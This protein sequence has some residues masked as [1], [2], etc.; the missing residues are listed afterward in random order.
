[1]MQISPADMLKDRVITA[2]LLIPLV[3]YVV[4][5]SPS[6]L[7]ALIL[8]LI[9]LIAANEW[10]HIAKFKQLRTGLFTVILG[11]GMLAGL[12][13]THQ[14]SDIIL[15]LSVLWWLCAL[16]GIMTYPRYFPPGRK[17][18]FAK[19][20]A[21]LLILL[22]AYCAMLRLHQAYS[23]GPWLLLCLFIIIWAADTGAFFFGKNFGR[24][25]LA[26]L[27]SPGKT[28]EGMLGGLLAGAIAAI[29]ST[30]MLYLPALQSVLFVGLAVVAIIVSVIGDLTISMFKR[31]VGLKDSGSL[32]PG[33]GGLLDRID[34]LVSAM[35]IFALG[36]EWMRL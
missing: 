35:P 2:A 8:G 6:F 14:F 4:L 17:L 1:M 36:L 10:E 23:L 26:P 34:S 13:V 16:L 9:F 31:H 7:F 22:P 33:H 21:G 12:L 18:Y 29:L 5:F 28:W 19:M 3:I 32:L 20:V 15:S 24:H 27:V 11:A 30:R 25:K